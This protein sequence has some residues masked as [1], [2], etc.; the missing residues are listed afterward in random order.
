MNLFMKQ[1]RFIDIAN[2]CGCQGGGGGMD[3][4]FGIADASHDIQNG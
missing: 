4:E 2:R 3:W 1:N